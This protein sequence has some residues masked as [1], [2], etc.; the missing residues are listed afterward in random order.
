MILPQPLLDATEQRA[1][2]SPRYRAPMRPLNEML[3]SLPGLGRVKKRIDVER[4]LK[5]RD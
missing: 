2:L 3:A 1:Q 5:G 4:A